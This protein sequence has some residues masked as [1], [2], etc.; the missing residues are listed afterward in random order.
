MCQT[1]F[2][3]T[4]RVGKTGTS[5]TT[6]DSAD[7][8]FYSV[9]KLMNNIFFLNRPS[10]S[11]SDSIPRFRLGVDRGF[12]FSSDNDNLERSIQAA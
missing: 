6:V 5:L 3:G 2:N 4:R 11:N 7:C 10:D 9:F 1:A 8:F 12:E